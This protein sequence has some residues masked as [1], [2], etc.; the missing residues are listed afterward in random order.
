L[1]GEVKNE[2]GKFGGILEKAEKQ[3]NTVSKSIGEAGRKTRT[4]SRALR[5]VESLPAAEVRSLLRDAAQQ[6][7]DDGSTLEALDPD[8]R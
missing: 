6:D 8:E 5:D 2:F 7:F 1:L 3:L 4:I